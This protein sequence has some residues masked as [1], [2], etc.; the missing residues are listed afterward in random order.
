MPPAILLTNRHCVVVCV[1]LQLN[2]TNLNP[3]TPSTPPMVGAVGSEDVSM[4][5]PGAVV[6]VVGLMGGDSE[7]GDYVRMGN[8]CCARYTRSSRGRLLAADA[9]GPE[10]L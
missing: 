5:R 6:V 7:D 8:R 10:G 9:A 3:A 1:T 4:L 2:F